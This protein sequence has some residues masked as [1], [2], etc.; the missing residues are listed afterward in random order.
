MVEVR[1]NTRLAA[2]LAVVALLLG[3]GFVMRGG[4]S[5]VVGVLLLLLGLAHAWLAWDARTPL[6]LVDEHGVRMRLGRTW[7]GLPWSEIDEVEHQPRAAGVR[8]WWRDGRLS[9]LPV[10]NAAQLEGLSGVALRLGRLAERMYGVPFA[11]PLGLGTTVTGADDGLTDALLALAPADVDVVEIDP[12]LA[13]TGDTAD[14]TDTAERPGLAVALEADVGGLVRRGGLEDGLEDGLERNGLEGGLERNGLEG[15][16]EGPAPA[17]EP[18]V[19]LLRPSPT[20]SPL[21]E[22]SV[23]VRAEVVGSASL[24]PLD[25]ADSE[26]TQ[27]TPPL[28]IFAD[29]VADAETQ[30]VFDDLVDSGIVPA[31]NPVIGPAL[32]AAR[33]RVGLSVD[34]LADR[35]RIRPH[36]IESIE[37]DD[38]APCGGDFYARGHLRTLARVLGVDAGPLLAEYDAS[39]AHAPVDPRAVF[40]AELASSHGGGL[41]AMRGG[42]NWAVLVA[43]VMGVVLVWS[44]ARLVMA[45]SPTAPAPQISLDSGSSGT[46]SP[47]SKAAAPVP[48]VLSAAGGGAQVVVRDSSGTVVF[49]GSLAFGQS[50]ALKVSPPVRV[51]TSDGSLTVSIKGAK[52]KA[53]GSIGQPAQKTYTA[54]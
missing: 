31:A 51:Q 38:F 13:E 52:G 27:S 42:P 16:V 49:T 4:G 37:V 17:V 21:R 46:H 25:A 7:R 47:Y 1:R 53:I 39:Y 30:V 54:D 11:V 23:A 29:S 14:L 36:V 43:A 10:D 6:A 26:Q 41:R 45:G 2:A 15:G 33:E 40:Q 12:T 18:T 22:P 3:V 5:A 9:V 20:P 48:V 8:G 35:T 19:Q 34:Q 28:R 24:A 32:A 50:K 44:V